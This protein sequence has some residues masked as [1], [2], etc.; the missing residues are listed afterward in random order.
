VRYNGW[1]GGRSWFAGWMML[2]GRCERRHC[3]PAYRSKRKWAQHVHGEFPQ[4]VTLLAF[5]VSGA[6]EEPYRKFYRSCAEC[7]LK[8]AHGFCSPT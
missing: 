2:F 4:H 7:V 6:M 1:S 5:V 8:C 3:E